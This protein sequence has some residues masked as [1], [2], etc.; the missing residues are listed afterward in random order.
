M[1]ALI[2]QWNSKLEHAECY[3]IKPCKNVLAAVGL[4]MALH[5]FEHI[6]S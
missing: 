3:T 6:F 5:P 1:N 2:E 4:N